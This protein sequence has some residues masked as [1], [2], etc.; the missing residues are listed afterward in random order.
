MRAHRTLFA[1]VALATLHCGGSDDSAAPTNTG[2]S[3]A[4]GATGAAGGSGA[5]GTAGAAPVT[6]FDDLSF[7]MVGMSVHIS[8]LVEYRVV[9]NTDNV[10][11]ARGVVQPLGG[12]D[13]MIAVKRFVPRDPSQTYRLDFYA[14]VNSSGGFDG[15]DSVQTN[16]HAWRFETL[17]G[18]SGVVSL[19]FT[20]S[21]AFTDISQHPPG[22]PAPPK[23]IGAPL[24]VKIQNLGS[25]KG[26]PLDLHVVDVATGHVVIAHRYTAATEM[27]MKSS[28]MI[29]TTQKY[30]LDVSAA[31]TPMCVPN[32]E[33]TAGGIV[34]T[35]DPATATAGPCQTG[36]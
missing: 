2:A 7:S 1:L 24:S 9:G 34:S 16:D 18:A 27:L 26:K 28:G 22:T 25:L 19:S 14:D 31:G 12:P 4:G 3:G 11:R 33:V 13:A 36:P 21:F 8:Q 10:L 20:H 32:L 23:E 15:L 5:A 29:D 35:F 17:S 30:A 6:E